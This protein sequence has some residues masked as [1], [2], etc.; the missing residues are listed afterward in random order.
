MKSGGHRDNEGIK[1]TG[2]DQRLNISIRW[3]S[4]SNRTTT[5]QIHIG[6]TDKHDASSLPEGRQISKL[7]DAPASDEPNP[8]V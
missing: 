1:P 4:G 2:L 7:R 8:D 3:N 6:D 5:R